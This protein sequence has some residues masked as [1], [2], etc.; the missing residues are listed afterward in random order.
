MLFGK[1]LEVLACHGERVALWRVDDDEQLTFAQLDARAN[2]CIQDGEIWRA[3][4]DSR[5]FLPTLIA[6]WKYEKPVILMEA[7]HHNVRPVRGAIPEGTMV[8]KQTCGASGVERSL[9]FTG[10][11]VFAEGMRNLEGLGLDVDRAGVAAISLAH[12]YGFGCLALPLLLGGVPV[13]HV[14]TPLPMF[15]EKVLW[16]NERVFLPGVPAIWKMWWKMG[17]TRHAAIELALSAGSPLSGEL[18]RGIFAESGLKVHNFYGTTETGAIAFDRSLGPRPV[19]G[20]IGSVLN[21]VDLA[22]EGDVVSV[23]S[24][25]RAVGADA[26][27]S[28]DEFASEF[29][30]TTDLGRIVD[31]KLILTGSKASAINVAGRK[32]SP[33]KLERILMEHPGV[34]SVEVSKI[35]SLDPERF[36]EICAQ[37]TVSQEIGKR[38]LRQSLMGR[39]ETWE[40][41]RHWEIIQASPSH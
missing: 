12:S 8:I 28:T 40:I 33:G 35:P 9:F 25:S 24:D 7:G 19:S 30:E 10:P 14:P 23:K 6:A 16:R 2:D 27:L 22:I 38:E 11:Q 17:V 39:F 1:W 31:G 29:Y 41:P 36:E 13:H 5:D 37:V 34:E 18:E 32:V 3:D 26:L 20:E 4:G 21:G 15:I